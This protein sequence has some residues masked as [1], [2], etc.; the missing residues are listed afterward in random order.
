MAEKKTPKRQ[1]ATLNL[2]ETAEALGITPDELMASRGRGL[3]PGRLG[4]KKDG[5]LV[6]NR[7]DLAKE[8]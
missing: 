2:E 8:Q 4:Y 6:W 5:V 3:E 1:K 7:K